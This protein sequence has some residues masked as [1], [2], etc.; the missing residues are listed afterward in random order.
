MDNS[1][2]DWRRPHMA[3]GE[4]TYRGHVI[5]IS[6]NLPMEHIADEIEPVWPHPLVRGARMILGLSDR[7][8]CFE[9][10]GKIEREQI[11]M[12]AGKVFMSAA[13]WDSLAK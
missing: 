3:R 6:R 8:V 7:P 13:T 2:N 12:A 1:F 5:V 10:R 4:F 11:V 9:R